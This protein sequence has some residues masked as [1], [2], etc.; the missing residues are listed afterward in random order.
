MY[1]LVKYLLKHWTKFNEII[2]GHMSTTG[3]TEIQNG[4]QSKPILA[5]TEMSV[6]LHSSR[7]SKSSDQMF[8]FVVADALIETGPPSVSPRPCS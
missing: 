1:L 4:H 2:T 7:R 5:N 8:F 6:R 3:A